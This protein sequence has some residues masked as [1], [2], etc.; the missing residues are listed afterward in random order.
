MTRDSPGWPDGSDPDLPDGDRSDEDERRLRPLPPASLAIAGIIGLFGGWLLH[1]ATE[2]LLGTAPVVGW[3]QGGILFFVAGLLLLVAWH[4]RRVQEGPERLEPHRAV[5]RLVLARA[6]ALVGG[7]V[8]GGYVGYAIS[9]L[10]DPAE[11]A[12]QRVLRSLLAATGG[13]AIATS[14]V[15]LERACRVPSGD[16]RP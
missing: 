9:W 8:A 16:P 3:L 6:C 4:T 13:V 2:R 12:D 1:P 5:N 10:G 11:L 7:V 14:A 15:V